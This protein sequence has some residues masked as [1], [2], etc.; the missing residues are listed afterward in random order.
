MPAVK[1]KLTRPLLSWVPYLFNYPWSVTRAFCTPSRVFS[2]ESKRRVRD[3][4]PLS[5]IIMQEPI[6]SLLFLRWG[7]G[8]VPAE[9]CRLTV[10]C[11]W[12]SLLSLKR[13]TLVYAIGDSLSSIRKMNQSTAIIVPHGVSIEMRIDTYI[14][15]YIIFYRLCKYAAQFTRNAWFKFPFKK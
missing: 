5:G 2:R 11:V 9:L 4:L 7:F 6:R 12:L 10:K 15:S 14:L 13:R 8:L 1:E 3:I